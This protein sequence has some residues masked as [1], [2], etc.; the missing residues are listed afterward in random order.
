MYESSST[1]WTVVD[2]GAGLPFDTGSVEPVKGE[3][4]TGATSGAVGTAIQAVVTSGSWAAGTAAGT[5]YIRAVT[6]S[7]VAEAATGSTAAAFNATAVQ[8]TTTIAPGGHYEFQSYN[9]YGDA[10]SQRIY[11]VSGVDKAFQFDGTGYVP[12]ST[13]MA[14][15]TPRHLRCHRHHLFLSFDGS[16]QHSLPGEP[17]LWSVVLGAGE[18]GIGDTIVSL[19]TLPGDIL[20]IKSRSST[21][22]LYGTSVQDWNLVAA[23]FDVGGIEWTAQQI[24]TLTYMDDLGITT[25]GATQS[26]GDFSSATISQKIQPLVDGRKDKVSASMRVK[27]KDQYRVFFSD[28][29]YIVG[30]FSKGKTIG[31]ASGELAHDVTCTAATE[32]ELGAETLV[33]GSSNGFVYEMDVGTSF[34]G[35]AIEHVLRLAF[36]H[37]KS[38]AYRKRFFK[39]IVEINAPSA[40]AFNVTA[41]LDYADPDVAAPTEQ[42]GI[43]AAAGGYWG[44]ATWGA[45][46]WD[47][48]AVANIPLYLDGSGGNMNLTFHASAIYDEPHTIQGLTIHYS[49]RGMSR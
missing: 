18:I 11:G 46:S 26:F 9:F 24:N 22:F 20:G 34:D 16:L 32:N 25:V 37:F 7:F 1:G 5:L 15:D 27:S 31:W 17:L 29:S 12:I 47:A 35:A 49:I 28:K 36:N 30:T 43:T 42:S 33:F 40:I 44:T 21:H 4:L 13:G 6:G 45:F 48:A 2:L 38:P 23:S 14:V 8:V 41:D 39:A 10:A 3:V 19:N